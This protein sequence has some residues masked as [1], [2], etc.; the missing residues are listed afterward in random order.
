M[1]LRSLLLTNFTG[2]RAE[3]KA[4]GAQAAQSAQ[5]ATQLQ[6]IFNTQF[7]QQQDILRNLTSTLTP[8]LQTGWTPA[9][10]AATQT[11]AMQTTAAQYQGAQKAL[12]SQMAQRGMTAATLPSGTAASLLAGIDTAAAQQQSTNFLNLAMQGQQNQMQAAQ[13]LAGPV[14]GLAGSMPQSGSLLLSANQQAFQQAKQSSWGNFFGGLLQSGIQGAAGA[15]TGGLAGGLFSN[16]G[17][18]QTPQQIG[19]VWGSG[20]MTNMPRG[21]VPQQ[22]LPPSMVAPTLGGV[23]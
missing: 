23:A 15:L 16:A 11:A 7:S 4:G 13:M 20:A 21:I 9:A 18:Q 14:A 5:F 6:G 17:W 1:N 19:Q 2:W 3:M 22:Q 12:L 10:Q 8:I